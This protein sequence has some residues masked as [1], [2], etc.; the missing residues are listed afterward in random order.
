MREDLRID[1]YLVG[2]L[3]GVVVAIL[4]VGEYEDQVGSMIIQRRGS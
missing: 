1:G 2:E 3:G 4:G